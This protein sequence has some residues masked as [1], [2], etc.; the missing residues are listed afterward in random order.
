MPQAVNPL[1]NLAKLPRHLAIIMDGNG[2]WARLRSL[3]RIAGHMQGVESVREV[4]TTCRELGIK[5]LTLYAF[6]QENWKRPPIEVNALM[7]LLSEYLVK[8]LTEMLTHGISLRV[9]GEAERLPRPVYKILLRT[10]KQTESNQDMIL[11]LALSYS[12]R[13][14]IVRAVREIGRRIKQ[15]KLEPDEISE[16]Y[17]SQILDTAGLPDPDLLIRTSGEYRLSNFLLW[18]M[19]YTE[20]YVTDVLWP[21][22]RREQLISALLDYQKRERR[23]GL[24]GE[25]VQA[26]R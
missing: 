1:L 14:E 9:I 2:R 12:G 6:S 20:I 7:G 15:E 5:A 4:V 3:N 22:F 18:Q 13:N 24:T 23:F 10:I 16:E 17:I 19:A 26:N 25:Q 21:D 8:E 11:T